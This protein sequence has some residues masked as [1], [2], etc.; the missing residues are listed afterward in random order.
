M[1]N[2]FDL[3]PNL[4]QFLTLVFVLMAVFAF[5]PVVQSLLFKV[6]SLLVYPFICRKCLSFWLNLFVCVVLAYVWSPCFVIWG[7]VTSSIIAYC[8]HYTEK[9]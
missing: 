4:W 8:I 2:L 9:N 3:V 1:G 6:S 7:A 5:T